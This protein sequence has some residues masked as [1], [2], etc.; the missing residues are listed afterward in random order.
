MRLNPQP[1][2]AHLPDA[3]DSRLT[4]ARLR[5]P[6]RLPTVVPSTAARRYLQRLIWMFGGG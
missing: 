4:F 3:R 5:R 1:V 2:I 6:T